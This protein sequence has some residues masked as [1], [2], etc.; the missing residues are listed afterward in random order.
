MGTE[1]ISNLKLFCRYGLFIID[2]IDQL[3]GYYKSNDIDI[4]KELY[5]VVFKI[6]I[7]VSEK[8]KFILISNNTVSDIYNY[9]NNAAISPKAYHL[10][11]LS[12]TDASN[13][14]SKLT[15]GTWRPNDIKE[16][17]DVMTILK[18]NPFEIHKLAKLKNQ[19]EIKTLSKLVQ[20][21]NFKNK[22]ERKLMNGTGGG[23]NE[24]YAQKQR[25]QTREQLI[26]QFIS[27]P[28]AQQ[29]WRRAHGMKM[30]QYHK[31]FDV[32]KYDFSEFTFSK[33]KL[34]QNSLMECFRTLGMNQDLTLNIEKFDPIYNWFHG[35][36][37][38]VQTLSDYYNKTNPVVIH[39]FVSRDDA[40]K[41]LLDK[42]RN[43]PIGTFIIRF[44]YKQPKSIAISYKQ[45]NK[46]I[47]N[48]KCD[49]SNNN[50]STFICGKKLLPL[51]Q[52]I[53]TFPP[54]KYL[55]N[56]Q[57][58]IPKESVFNLQQ[59]NNQNNQNNPSW[60]NASSWNPP[61]NKQQH[62]YNSH[63][64]QMS[65]VPTAN[66]YNAHSQS[67]YHRNNFSPQPQNGYHASFNNGNSSSSS[68][69]TRR[70]RNIENAFCFFVLSS[71]SNIPCILYI[72]FSYK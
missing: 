19:C 46:N 37:R 16:N 56:L 6:L 49:L 54:L 20:S 65:H 26:K 71:L 62:Q 44:R 59:N 55:Y 61:T 18:N 14:F 7:E 34:E 48:I 57:S 50:D 35:L 3:M 43:L 13:L 25:K 69:Q 45:S 38:L 52:F 51:S 67:T 27:N 70:S 41:M 66:P 47:S 28:A 68:S 72:K 17:I 32:L 8:I 29:V 2:D 11:R 24:A 4:N 22:L 36:T 1:L 40:H 42:H 30:C 23:G 21:H 39:G 63:Q 60:N 53:L 15:A 9:N 58:P 12:S 10:K 64:P 5:S 31:I 33:R